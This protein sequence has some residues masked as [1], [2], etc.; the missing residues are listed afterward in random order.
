[1]EEVVM[2]LRRSRLLGIGSIVTALGL[3]VARAYGESP[4]PKVI[5]T[6]DQVKWAPVASLRPGAQSAVMLGAP[7]K[8]GPYVY[9]VKFPP[10]FKVDAHSHPDNRTYTVLSGTFYQGLGDKFDET[11]L[12]ARPAG[13]FYTHAAG[14]P[15]F[16]ATRDEEVVLQIASCEGS[17]TL[18]YVNPADDPRTTKK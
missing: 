9:R 16:G 4:S 15:H 8:P 1:M 2:T 17:T 12:M 5:L 13:S 11:K 7:D 6:P 18:T 14:A 3:L 10:N